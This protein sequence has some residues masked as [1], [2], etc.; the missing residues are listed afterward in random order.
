MNFKRD[1]I[2]L[3]ESGSFTDTISPNSNTPKEYTEDDIV[4]KE[5]NLAP[6]AVLTQAQFEQVQDAINIVTSVDQL[7]G[8]TE[9][10]IIGFNQVSDNRDQSNKMPN[11]EVFVAGRTLPIPFSK[12]Q[13]PSIGG[14]ALVYTIPEG[15]YVPVENK[16]RKETDIILYN[17]YKRDRIKIVAIKANPHEA[18]SINAAARSVIGNK[19]TNSAAIGSA[20]TTD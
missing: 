11:W 15:A 13:A 8:A 9:M 12:H 10:R 17:R 3:R 2:R 19:L 6:D 7:E 4:R 20:V 16:I 5:L 14:N 1:S 18:A